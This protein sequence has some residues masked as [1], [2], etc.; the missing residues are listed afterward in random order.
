MTFVVR[1]AKQMG[2]EA[3]LSTNAQRTSFS[4]T[5]Q[6]PPRPSADPS[7]TQDTALLDLLSVL[8]GFGQQGEGN[9][10]NE[11]KRGT[12][13][14]LLS[15]N[16]RELTSLLVSS[17]TRASLVTFQGDTVSI[18]AKQ[19]TLSLRKGLSLSDLPNRAC[20]THAVARLSEQL[21]LT[22]PPRCRPT[23]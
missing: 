9:E 14:A 18:R 20:P 3:Q 17:R 13:H 15:V 5:L 22:K 11:G 8:F 21:P 19:A 6:P 12:A 7:S 10:G 2:E 23:W 16:V 4:I 1:R